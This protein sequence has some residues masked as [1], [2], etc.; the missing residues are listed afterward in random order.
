MKLA[1]SGTYSSGKTLT[2]MALS[3]Y[4]GIPRTLAKSIR[5]IMPQA[6]PGKILAQCT[7]AEYLQL[8][9]RRHVERVANES[10]LPNGFISDG[11]SLQEWIYGAVRVKYGMNPSATAHLKVVEAGELTDEMRFFADV[12]A[13]FGHA[14]KQHV[15]ATFDAYVH[16]R[17]ELPL[18]NDGHRPM[19]NRFR[20]ECD[21]ML[22]RTL[23]ELEIPYHVIGGS[24]A[25]RLGAI[26]DLFDLPTVME[27]DEAV[28]LA[29]QEYARQDLRFETERRASA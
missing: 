16:L 20:D 21:H 11:S 19:N 1:I 28:A 4:T 7:P 13:Q 6:V 17:N 18:T 15:K 10:V 26:V 9:L 2:V 12:V 23:D 29:R 14:F 24:L 3:H 25:E 27:V 22:L 5:E 8:A